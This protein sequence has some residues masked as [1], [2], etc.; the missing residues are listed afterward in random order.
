MSGQA[1]NRIIVMPSS[2]GK[3]ST[4][5]P[6]HRG[7][8]RFVRIAGHDD[9]DFHPKLSKDWKGS[10][11]IWMSGKEICFFTAD[12]RTRPGPSAPSENPAI[13]RG[14]AIVTFC[15]ASFSCQGEEKTRQ[16][17]LESSG[18]PGFQVDLR[19][20]PNLGFDLP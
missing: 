19:L 4:A 11:N 7:L 12:T 2:F 9:Q 15:E 6:S 1:F 16:T 20:V 5:C 3:L 17:E 14:L 10:D 8:Q 13:G 18:Y